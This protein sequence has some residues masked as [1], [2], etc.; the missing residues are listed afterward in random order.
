LNVVIGL[1]VVV[2][3]V[4]MAM[5][6][7]IYQSQRL[8]EFGLLQALGYTKGALLARAL[9]ESALVVLAGWLLGVVCAFG[10]LTLVRAILMEP[11]AFMLDPWDKTAYLYTAP[12]PVSIFLAAALTVMARFRR[13]DP[14]GVVERR[15]V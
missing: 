15:L 2:I 14:V 6:M 5:L 13:F 4:M 9:A 8:Q 12:V 11:R 3:T 10:L 7:N 1:L